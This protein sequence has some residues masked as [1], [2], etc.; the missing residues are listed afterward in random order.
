[1]LHY[2]KRRFSHQI[3]YL[4]NR[5]RLS[6]TLQFLVGVLEYYDFFA[7]GFVFYYL[8]QFFNTKSTAIYEIALISLISFIFRPVG[9]RIYLKI[10]PKFSRATIITGNSILMTFAIVST[11]LMPADVHKLWLVFLWLTIGR[12]LHGISFGFKLQ[13]NLRFIKES[14]PKR[15]HSNIASSIIGAQLGL[16]CAAF[17]YKI[18]FTHLTP[19]Q[20]QWGWRIPFFIGGGISVILFLFRITIY[21]GNNYEVRTPWHKL[22][23]LDVVARKSGRRLWLGL[24]IASSRAGMIFTLFVIVPGF[25][26]WILKWDIRKTTDIMLAISL[27]SGGTSWFFRRTKLTLAKSKLLLPALWLILPLSTILAY[28][29]S[30]RYD[31][32]TTLDILLLAVING[33]LFVAIPQYVENIFTP[34]YR[35]EAMLFIGN[36]EYFNFNLLRRAGLFIL[37]V[38]LG[39]LVEEKHYLMMLCAAIWM[40]ILASITAIIMLERQRKYYLSG[41]API[42]HRKNTL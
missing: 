33:Y 41:Y 18:I 23:P 27:L 13:S 14:F 34:Q 15:I 38:F 2:L 30:H 11:G 35:L 29:L 40:T 24:I 21:R 31:T 5:R 22:E 10:R 6:L 25:F 20:L 12:I 32:L 3:R 17:V 7:F 8:S 19:A 39:Q 42:H 4:R 37:I 28:S 1:M 26:N 36:F 16:T 9:Y